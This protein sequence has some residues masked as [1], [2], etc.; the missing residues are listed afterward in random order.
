MERGIF[1]SN[2]AESRSLIE[3]HGEVEVTYEGLTLPLRQMVSLCP[4][5]E[6]EM[7]P[8]KL[9]KVAQAFLDG[10]SRQEIMEIINDLQ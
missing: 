3:T 10:K 5:D 9:E 7:D 4:K 6:T 2:E 1:E 8:A